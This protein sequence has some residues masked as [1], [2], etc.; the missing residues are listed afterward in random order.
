MALYVIDVVNSLLCSF[1]HN[2]VEYFANLQVL[3]LHFLDLHRHF[4]V[5]A[6]E[7]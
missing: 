5:F 6:F 7:L 2:V 3:F 4:L 1:D